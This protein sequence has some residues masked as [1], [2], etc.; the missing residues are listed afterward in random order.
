AALP[1]AGPARRHPSPG[2]AF[3]HVME[4]PVSKILVALG[5]IL[6]VLIVAALTAHYRFPYQLVA[7]TAVKNLEVSS[8]LRISFSRLKPGLPFTYGFDDVKLSLSLPTGEMPL[9]TLNK[10]NLNLNPW[11]LLSSRFNFSLKA[12]SGQGGLSGRIEYDYFGQREFQL[13]IKEIKLPQFTLTLPK[14]AGGLSGQLSGHMLIRGKAGVV[15]TDG[16][17]SITLTQ[18]RVSDIKI[19]TLPVSELDLDSLEVEFKLNQ[20]K[21]Q[22]T[23]LEGRARQGEL[24]L[25]GQIL[26]FKNPRL[27]LSGQMR[28]A[29]AAG[30]PLVK[31]SLRITGTLDDPSFSLTGSGLPSRGR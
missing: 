22:I 6:Y 7:R 5:L 28:M 19:S 12:H 24:R 25:V 18:G 3:G 2:H 21:V 27:L 16:Q 17:G 29:G 10:V 15:P 13:E 14:G 9:L 26:G 31:S 1:V 4:R 8:P 23:R 30:K 20:D 11:S